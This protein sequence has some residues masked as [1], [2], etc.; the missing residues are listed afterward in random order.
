M[1]KT[2]RTKS[3]ETFKDLEDDVTEDDIVSY[4]IHFKDRVTVCT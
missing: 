2:Q 3:K 4:Y 1:K